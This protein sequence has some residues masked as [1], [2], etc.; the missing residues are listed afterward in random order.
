[1][2]IRRRALLQVLILDHR[3]CFLVKVALHLVELALVF[4]VHNEVVEVLEGLNHVVEADK[5][6]LVDVQLNPLFTH[7]QFEVVVVCLYVVFNVIHLLGGHTH[8]EHRILLCLVVDDLAFLRQRNNDGV[9]NIQ[10]SRL[11]FGLHKVIP[12]HKLRSC[13]LVISV[14]LHGSETFFS[15]AVDDVKQLLF[16]G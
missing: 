12:F 14:L 5:A 2:D 13:Y 11:R 4:V 16:L 8:D 6:I 15:V 10:N 1:M 9:I 3:E 7:D